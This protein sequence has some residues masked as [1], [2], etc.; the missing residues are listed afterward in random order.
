M[1]DMKLYASQLRLYPGY[2]ALRLGGWLRMPVPRRREEGRW[3]ILFDHT[4]RMPD[5]S[6]YVHVYIALH[7]PHAV[8]VQGH[9]K[10]LSVVGNRRL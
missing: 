10:S 4:S 6:R 9:V 7:V 2:V 8:H 3:G 1:S 5:G